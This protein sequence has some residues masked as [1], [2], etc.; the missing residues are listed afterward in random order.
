M[1]D[2][3]GLELS[4]GLGLSC[5]GS[6]GKPKIVYVPSDTKVEADSRPDTNASDPS[7]KNF[8]QTSSE[9]QD[10]KGKEKSDPILPQN[11][12]F[13]TDLVKCPASASASASARDVSNDVHNNVSQFNRYQE[14][15]TSK[16]KTADSEENSNK[17]KM[18]FEEV[19]F[20]NKHEKVVDYT[21]APH[22]NPSNSNIITNSKASNPT[23]NVSTGENEDIEESETEGSNSWLVSQHEDKSKCSDISQYTDKHVLRDS[24]GIVSKGQKEPSASGVGASHASG[25]VAYGIRSSLHPLHV[26]TAPYPMPVKVA[27]TPNAPNQTRFP[28]P[29]VMQGMP[30][31][32]TERSSGQALSTSNLQLA[33]GYS[34][35]QLPTLET[36]SSW[37]FNSQPRQVTSLANK[38]NADRPASSEHSGVKTSHVSAHGPGVSSPS[39]VYEGKSLDLVKANGKHAGEVG[40]SSKTQDEGKENFSIFRP[41]EP[42][43]S[44]AEGFSQRGATIKPG[45]ASEIKFGGCGSCPNLP[46]V[47]ATGS[48]PN[49]KTISGVAYKLG[50]NQVKI[51]CACHGTHMSQEE[52]LQ[53]ASADASKPEDNATFLDNNPAASAKS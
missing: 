38:D 45:I 39:V 29:C 47:S 49:G 52:F 31:V 36:G 34:S 42:T 7:F 1:E 33:F 16:N 35:V 25:E 4:L 48:G 11:E 37:A 19:M 50:Q 15:W 46:W 24:R 2:E 6:S 3:N 13:W 23:E 43:R 21:G 8:F 9:C 22:K 53:H 40:T 26:K 27:T 10:S 18:P 17:R 30:I 12:K 28:S 32:A 14:L 20:Q 41:K 44:V 5:G 51:V